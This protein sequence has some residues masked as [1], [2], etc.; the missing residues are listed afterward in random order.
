MKNYRSR[1][2]LDNGSSL[3]I[4]KH[5]FNKMSEDFSLEELEKILKMLGDKK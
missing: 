4:I 2:V 3:E 5:N 1:V